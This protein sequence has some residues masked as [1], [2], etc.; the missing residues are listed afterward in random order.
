MKNSLYEEIPMGG[1][2]PQYRR[3]RRRRTGRIVSF[4]VLLSTIFVLIIGGLG[5][6]FRMLN[7][8]PVPTTTETRTFTLGA[9]TYPLLLM[10]NDEGFVHVRPGNG[11][12][13][14][15]TTTKVGGSFGASPDDF[16]VNYAQSGTIITIHVLN[17]S[18]HLF[19]FSQASHADLDVRVPVDSDLQLE[20]DSGDISV[21]GIHG[22]MTLSSNS[23]SLQANDILLERG[24]QLSADSG[25]LT[26]SGSLG[27][28]G[29]SL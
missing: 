22:K 15:I 26:M 6:A 1:E 16:K 14:I 12:T 10:T 25:S 29:R 19:D 4:V 7:P 9:G 11:N 3:M 24:S 27:A 21:T 18:I 5:V 2:V 13:I 17:D 28:D 20:T 23:G 8:T